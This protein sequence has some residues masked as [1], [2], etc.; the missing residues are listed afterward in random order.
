MNKKLINTQILCTSKEQ[1][2]EIV[3]FYKEQGF[4]TKES[5]GH[6]VD[7]Y[8]GVNENGFFDVWSYS[9]STILTLPEAK[10]LASD[11]GQAEFWPDKVMWVWEGLLKPEPRVTF[12]KKNNKWL[13]WSSADNLDDAKNIMYTNSWPYA[14]ETKPLPKFTK[15]EIAEKLGVEDFEIEG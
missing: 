10:A 12:G 13:A 15:K 9:R 3:K 6:L 4:D 8:Y 5:I 7:F 14:S 1:G 2:A 11:E